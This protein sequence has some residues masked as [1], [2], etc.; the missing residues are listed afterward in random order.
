[1][2]SNFAEIGE[3]LSNV[4]LKLAMNQNI[5]K[6]LYYN[7]ESPLT[8]SD[9]DLQDEKN[10]LLNKNIVLVPSIDLRSKKTSY[11][12]IVTPEGTINEND[13]FS[14]IYICIDVIVPLD[15]WLINNKST[16]PILL[17]NEIKKTLNGHKV[18]SIGTMRFDT[19]SLDIPTDEVS[20]YKM[21]FEVDI[22]G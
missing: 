19:Y 7:D 8:Y 16:R 14:T 12:S 6:L 9:L 13:E 11:L 18:N 20:V 3:A 4:A 22:L 10:N 1:M 15:L 2:A 5:T 21:V 17:M